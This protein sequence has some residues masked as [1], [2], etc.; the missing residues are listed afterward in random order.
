MVEIRQGD[1]QAFFRAPFE[2]YGKNSLYVTPMWSDVDRYFD[3]AKNPLFK[4]GNPFRLLTAHRDGRPVGR[5]CAHLHQASNARHSLKRAYFGFFDVANDSEAADALLAAARDFAGEHGCTELAGNFNLTAMQQLGV[6]TG[7]FE[8]TPYTDMMYS[9]PH[10]SRHLERNGFERFFPAGTWEIDLR[11]CDPERLLTTKSRA[12]LSAPEVSWAPIDRK[13]FAERLE[14]AR[15]A[16]NDGFDQNPMF[17]PLTQEEYHFQA[18]EMMWILDPRL[19]T[20]TRIGG[21]VAGVVLCIPDLNPFI[22]RVKGKYGLNAPFEFLRHRLT[23]KRAVIIY[24]SVVRAHQGNGLNGAMLYRTLKSL[25]DAGYESLGI[26]WIADVNIA[27][28]KQMERLGA[29]QLHR[30]HLFRKALA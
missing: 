2:A 18:S 22:R 6:T 5:I 29:R 8:N 11:A 9:P 27:S 7:G 26:T 12:I 10:I 4:A 13:H 15:N 19:S 24:Y 3:A 1:K 21:S 30:Q 28:L 25:R 16:L 23:R 20:C 17:V 14:D